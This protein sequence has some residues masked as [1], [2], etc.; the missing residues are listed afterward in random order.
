[1][2]VS[3]GWELLRINPLLAQKFQKHQ[4]RLALLSSLLFSFDVYKSIFLKGF[5]KY[6]DE[7]DV[8]TCLIFAE[9][10]STPD[11]DGELDL[12][13]IDDDEIDEVIT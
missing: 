8:H 7:F 10:D 4:E 5:Q 12:S 1:M 3:E 9:E 2:T 11:S 13:G 6:F